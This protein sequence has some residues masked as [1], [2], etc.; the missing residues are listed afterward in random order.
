MRTTR[1]IPCL[2]AGCAILAVSGF[3]LTAH[4]QS[5]GATQQSTP[6]TTVVRG[7]E[8][9]AT[10]E[11]VDQATR[12]VLL[13]GNDGALLTVTAGP[14]VQNLAQI[15]AGDQVVLQYTEALAARLARSDPSGSSAPVNVQS[16]TMRSAPGATPAAAGA[17][18]VRT[19]IQVESVDRANNILTF[20]GPTGAVRRVAV[21]DPDAQRF[22]QTLRPGDRVDI[23]YTEALAVALQ[24]M[25]R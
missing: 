23:E 5:G 2:A 10:V 13:R 16:S 8:A 24:P 9:R 25:Q 14:Q 3:S 12:H 15:K 6:G 4:A 1:L 17:D 11:S 22:L 7:I 20:M 19:T 18:Q 21:H